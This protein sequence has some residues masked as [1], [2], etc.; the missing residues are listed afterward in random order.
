MK[1]SNR[2]LPDC[3]TE[4][5]FYFK[6]LYSV[7]LTIIGINS[8]EK[9]FCMNQEQFNHAHILS[10]T[11]INNMS[12]FKK[13]LR[14]P[15][16]ISTILWKLRIFTLTE[17][18]IS[19]IFYYIKYRFPPFS[20]KIFQDIFESTDTKSWKGVKDKLQIVCIKAVSAS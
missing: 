2:I 7:F 1:G 12:I 6:E 3:N 9:F 13:M 5:P 17:T 14:L 18:K 8:G 10:I 16:P 4:L 19:I 20:H 15:M 11:I